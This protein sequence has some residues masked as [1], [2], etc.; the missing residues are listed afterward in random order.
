M[1]VNVT[2][3]FPTHGPERP[4]VPSEAPAGLHRGKPPVGLH[5]GK[6]P[7]GLHRGKGTY[8]RRPAPGSAQ[9]GP[10]GGVAL[11]KHL[12]KERA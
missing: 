4:M 11:T 8:P 5:R 3:Q 1:G 6:P 2:C 9:G 7:V 12:A 10:M